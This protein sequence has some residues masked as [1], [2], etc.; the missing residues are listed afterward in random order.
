MQQ[1]LQE[2]KL[3]RGTERYRIGRTT[4]IQVLSFEEDNNQAQYNRLRMGLEKL[5]VEAQARFYNAQ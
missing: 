1:S 5:V 4:A 2:Q 3:Q